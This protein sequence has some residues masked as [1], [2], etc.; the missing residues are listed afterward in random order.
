MRFGI[1]GDIHSNQE[2][3]EAVLDDMQAQRVTHTV[4][5]GDIVGY[6]ANPAECLE[7][8]RSLGCPVVK[9]NHDEEASEDRPIDHFNPLAFESMTYSRK[10]LSE[11][12]KKYLRSLLMQKTI[13]DFTVVHSSLDG[14]A[15]W[16][17]VFALTEAQ[18]SFVYQRTQVCFYGHT[19]VPTAYILEDGGVQ[20]CFYKRLVIQENK[21]YYINVG[22]VGQPRDGDWRAAYAIYDTEENTVDL[23]RVPYDINLAQQKIIEAGLPERLAERLANAV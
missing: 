2:A 10:Q 1:F 19:H 13:H 18:N 12:Q 5:I 22:S 4:C 23:R 20:E 15:R 17:Y 3:L 9:G 14:P 8:V 6:N 16:I 7:L 21:Q 11:D